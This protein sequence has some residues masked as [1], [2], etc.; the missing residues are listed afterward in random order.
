MVELMQI[1]IFEAKANYILE[2]AEELA[3]TNPSW[4]DFCNS[5][6]QQDTGLISKIFP[7]PEERKKFCFSFQ[8]DKVREIRIRLMKEQLGEV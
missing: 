8:Y 7:D 5:I 2:T 6:S 1:D 3:S 4:I